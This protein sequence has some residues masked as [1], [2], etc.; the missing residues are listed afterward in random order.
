MH[1][2]DRERVI[3]LIAGVLLAPRLDPELVGQKDAHELLHDPQIQGAV[4]AARAIC[5]AVEDQESRSEAVIFEAPEERA[6]PSSEVERA[7]R[8]LAELGEPPGHER[9]AG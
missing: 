3:A 4:R 2:E 1:A 7:A 6:Q 8:R 9:K 5:D